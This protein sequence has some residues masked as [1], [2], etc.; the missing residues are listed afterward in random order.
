M[1]SAAFESSFALISMEPML[2]CTTGARIRS[3]SWAAAVDDSASR[4]GAETVTVSANTLDA[5]DTCTRVS[6]SAT[7]SSVTVCS[8]YPPITTFISYEPGGTWK[9]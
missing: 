7:T 3:I 4:L 6:S 9:R 8:A 2:S 1:A 5:S